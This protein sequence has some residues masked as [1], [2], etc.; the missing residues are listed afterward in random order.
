MAGTRFHEENTAKSDCVET[1][2]DHVRCKLTGA[3]FAC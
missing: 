3:G 2:I 1:G